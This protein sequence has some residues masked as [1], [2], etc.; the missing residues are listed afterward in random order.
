MPNPERTMRAKKIELF[1]AYYKFLAM[2]AWSVNL[3]IR[4]SGLDGV[5]QL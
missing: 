3:L 5:L 4:I 2:F 1:L